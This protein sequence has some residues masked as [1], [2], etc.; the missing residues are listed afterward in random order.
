MLN[1]LALFQ[2]CKSSAGVSERAVGYLLD[3]LTL[4]EDISEAVV[5]SPNRP[6]DGQ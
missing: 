1:R 3:L 5:S 2:G 6:S 4:P